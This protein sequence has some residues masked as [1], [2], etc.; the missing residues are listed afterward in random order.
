MQ[1]AAAEKEQVVE[2]IKAGVYYYLTKPYDNDI[3]RSPS[4]PSV[5]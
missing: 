1:T 2:G 4:T 3:M 5:C